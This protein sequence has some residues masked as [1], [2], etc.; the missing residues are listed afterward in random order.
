V[1]GDRG[2]GEKEGKGRGRFRK[3]KGGRLEGLGEKGGVG[4]KGGEVEDEP[5]SRWGRWVFG[6]Y[7][8]IETR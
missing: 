6:G 8:Q 5:G 3:E 2:E 7:R 4:G 1:E